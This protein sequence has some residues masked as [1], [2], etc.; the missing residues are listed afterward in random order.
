MHLALTLKVFDLLSLDH[1]LIVGDMPQHHSVIRKCNDGG[2][3]G[4][5]YTVKSVR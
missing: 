5:T 1:L 4:R 2:G 3:A